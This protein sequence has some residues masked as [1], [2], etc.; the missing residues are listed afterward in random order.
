MDEVSKKGRTVLFVSHNM[1]A[2]AKLCS[3]AL[4]VENGRLGFLG[5]IRQGIDRYRD[6]PHVQKGHVNIENQTTNRQGL[7]EFS[8]LLG[9][10]TM[11]KDSDVTSTFKMGT[12]LIVK[13]DF[14]IHKI[15]DDIELTFFFIGFDN[16]YYGVYSNIIEG[17]KNFKLGRQSVLVE[18]PSL[19]LLPGN[20]S[21]GV[22]ITKLG[23][24]Q[25]DLVSPALDIDVVSDDCFTGH[26]VDYTRY[27]HYGVLSR[28]LWNSVA[29]E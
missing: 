2:I 17:Y 16:A 24:S 29:Y 7:K 15:V 28:S 1:F 3:K 6:A 14:E 22:W 11:N 5:D 25:D 26:S 8:Q 23:Q 10:T 13:I 19:N 4:L 27:R 21:I 20:H 18:I 9:I 12:T